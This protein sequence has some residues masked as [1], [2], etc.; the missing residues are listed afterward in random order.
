MITLLVFDLTAELSVSGVT[1]AT[2]IEIFIYVA[3]TATYFC[4]LPIDWIPQREK[5]E[6][7]EVNGNGGYFI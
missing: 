6:K 7:A 5:K 4:C 1:K 2:H 3:Y